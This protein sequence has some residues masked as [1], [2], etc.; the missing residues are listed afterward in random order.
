MRFNRKKNILLLINTIVEGLDYCEINIGEK[1]KNMI[2]DCMDAVKFIRD[3]FVEENVEIQLINEI[4][5]DLTLLFEL[6]NEGK[7]FIDKVI[8]IKNKIINL[9][10]EIVENIETNLYVTFM[11][12]K[13]SMWDS[14]E[15][16]WKAANEDEDCVCDIMPI[17][18][19]ELDMQG[20]PVKFCYEGDRFKNKY[21][22]INYENY[23]LEDRNPDIIYIHNPYDYGNTLTRIDDRFFSER[24]R[25]HCSKL[26]YVPYFVRGSLKV[27]YEIF[28][29]LPGTN[30]ADRIIAHSEV[31]KRLF[32]NCG[33]KEEKV[34]N[35][36]SPKYDRA[37]IEKDKKANLS[38]E[39]KAYVG[40]KKV[41]LLSTGIGDLLNYNDWVSMIDKI[42]TYFNDSE[43]CVLIW[44][45][46]PLTTR[47][48]LS[49]VPHMAIEYKNLLEKI[50]SSK[51]IIMDNNDEV[52]DSINI[53]DALISDYSSVMHQYIAIEKPV[54]GLL[55]DKEIEDDRN[56]CVDYRG[57]YVYN[58]D[59]TLEEFEKM[60]I[61]NEDPKKDERISTLKNSVTNLDGRCGEKI[62]NHIKEELIEELMKI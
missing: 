1:A 27:N 40:D 60:V 38:E 16:I 20:V 24:L 51:N 57:V 4:I 52:Y 58:K 8:E 26:V 36:G 45:R 25:E 61:N 33:H 2:L 29:G 35:L 6:N 17:P 19:Y 21:E 62:Y 7:S 55:R 5:N 11:P 54:L 41:I 37:L 15:S 13:I 44:R 30:N 32:M 10:K 49:M 39:M 46:H 3:T 31:H 42:I 28:G 14:L 18:Y 59:T 48:I 34:L 53:S 23:I 12:Y 56:Y 9:K 50:E 47:S 22:V 43:N